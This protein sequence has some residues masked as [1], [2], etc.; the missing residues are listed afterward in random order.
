M[1]IEG[2]RINYLNKEIEK[3]EAIRNNVI[4]S[5][6]SIDKERILFY[7]TK[8]IEKL[9]KELLNWEGLYKAALEET[10][11][12]PPTI[13][14]QNS[15]FNQDFVNFIKS[16]ENIQKIGFKNEKWFP[17]KSVEGGVPTI[18]YGHK[19]KNDIE[20]SHYSSGITD[21]EANRILIEDL[22]IAKQKV[23]SYIK[24]KYKVNIKLSLKQEEMLTEFAFNLGG[25][26]KFPKF[27]NSILRN[28]LEVTNNEYKRH[29]GGKELTG[30][31]TAFYN[32]YLKT[33]LTENTI[34][35]EYD[36]PLEL[37]KEA[38]IVTKSA[39]GWIFS[40]FFTIAYHRL[41]MK[42]RQQE[43]AIKALNKFPLMVKKFHDK[44]KPGSSKSI[45]L[46]I[47]DQLTWENL[48]RNTRHI[49][50]TM[51]KDERGTTNVKTDPKYSELD[52]YFY[53]YGDWASPD[54]EDP[55]KYY[56]ERYTND[57]EKA[58]E[59]VK[60][61]KDDF[62]FRF[63]HSI[64]E[65]QKYKSFR[66]PIAMIKNPLSNTSTKWK[67]DNGY[68]YVLLILAKFEGKE[69]PFYFNVVKRQ[70]DITVK[71]P[72]YESGNPENPYVYMTLVSDYITDF[73]GL[74]KNMVDKKVTTSKHEAIHLQQDIKKSG[75]HTGLPKDTL[76]YKR[77]IMVRGTTSS[78]DAALGSLH[79]DPEDKDNRVVHAYRDVEFKS[80]EL[81]MIKDFQK[82][83]GESL[84]IN[85]WKKG[86]KILIDDITG[87]YNQNYEARKKFKEVF[88]W[89]LFWDTSTAKKN[90]EN[91]YKN[92]LPKFRQ[93]VK[94]IYK[95]LFIS[96][97][98]I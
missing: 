38:E 78:G 70:K 37:E 28:D 98:E 88:K 9:K 75:T 39:I 62:I 50:V 60:K 42:E 32:R 49:I 46:T 36:L 7:M 61:Y 76:L 90:L 57:V 10:V 15:I 59:D 69:L 65:C 17:H 47:Y 21:E 25:L 5:T 58:W 30:R 68:P 64:S 12:M 29:T 13:T 16:I 45:K 72:D 4:K 82:I 52:G 71:Y 56:R 34:K 8:K 11:D 31:N 66:T 91:I 19:I 41:E 1:I 26:E 97:R 18:A 84:P 86:F 43:K 23:Y 20:L 54:R 6:K 3:L 40:P 89:T 85:D 63:V 53:E 14:Q 27:V 44:A 93:Y 74:D 73:N 55:E 77:N 96:Q 48:K 67:L 2:A 51:T 79:K 94:E 87:K 92:D 35:E 22:E 95:L 81:N 33:S 24:S 80:N 83:L